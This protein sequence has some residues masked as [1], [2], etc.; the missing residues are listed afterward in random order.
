MVT[1][2]YYPLALSTEA[3]ALVSIRRVEKFLLKE[4]KDEAVSCVEQS[5]STIAPDEKRESLS[6]DSLKLKRI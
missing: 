4:E 3:E 5:S 2:F 6:H 1:A